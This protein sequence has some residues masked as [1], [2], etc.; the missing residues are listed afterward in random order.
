MTWSEV[1]VPGEQLRRSSDG[2]GA[3]GAAGVAPSTTCSSVAAQDNCLM[4][5][6]LMDMTMRELPPSLAPPSRF[7]D[8]QTCGWRVAFLHPVPP[9]DSGGCHRGDYC[10]CPRNYTAIG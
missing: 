9:P 10:M 1:V 7:D 6:C 4:D 5:N 2:G 3:V 8:A